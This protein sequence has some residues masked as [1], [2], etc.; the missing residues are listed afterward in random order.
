MLV[1]ALLFVALVIADLVTVV[2]EQ[3]NTTSS[4]PGRLLSYRDQIIGAVPLT[5]IKITL[6]AW[7]IVS[8]VPPDWEFSWVY[9]HE[10]TSCVYR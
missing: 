4:W 8:Q 2:N 7:Q 1:V 9:S 10:R 5:A 6:V 3:A